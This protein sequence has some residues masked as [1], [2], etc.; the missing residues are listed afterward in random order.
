MKP[1]ILLLLLWIC[2]IQSPLKTPGKTGFISGIVEFKIR[3]MGLSVNGSMGISEIEFKQPSADPTTWSL[4]GNAA[5]G[6]ISTGIELRD[7]HLK[8]K[9]YFDIINYP[10]IRLQSTR[11]RIKGKNSY[12]GAFDLSIKEITKTVI[13]PFTILKKENANNVTGEFTI[14]RLDYRLGEESSIL[15]EKVV[16]KVSAIFKD[17]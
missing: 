10:V 1:V 4:E 2:E 7:K 16:I 11:I 14:N 8:K 9:D 17:Q 3:N 6:T 5:P 13:I 12:E 15:S